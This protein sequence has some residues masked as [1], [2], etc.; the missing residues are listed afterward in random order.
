M[1]INRYIVPNSTQVW[2]SKNLISIAAQNDMLCKASEL[3]LS[4]HTVRVH[5]KIYG[6]GCKHQLHHCLYVQPD[7]GGSSVQVTRERPWDILQIMA[8]WCNWR[9]T[10]FFVAS[11]L[12]KLLRVSAFSR[13]SGILYCT[14]LPSGTR[15]NISNSHVPNVQ[16]LAQSFNRKST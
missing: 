9:E 8:A 5:A 10:G 14:T 15:Q 6:R 11:M 3:K 13:R 1:F 12:T 2:L 4:Q 16:S 7:V